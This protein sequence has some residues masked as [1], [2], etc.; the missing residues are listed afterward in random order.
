MQRVGRGPARRRPAEFLPLAKGWMAGLP[1]GSCFCDCLLPRAK[2]QG[3]SQYWEGEGCFLC[4]HGT[5]LVQPRVR[6]TG[7][8]SA[9]LV[10]LRIFGG[11]LDKPE[12]YDSGPILSLTLMTN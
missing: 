5:G 2:E 11:F 6:E 7:H 3:Q 9:Q 4:T 8:R 1:V 10:I 12:S